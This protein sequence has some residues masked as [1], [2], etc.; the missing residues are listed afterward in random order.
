MVFIEHKRLYMTKGE[1][2]E[3]S[4]TIELDR[5]DTKRAGCDITIVAWSNMVPRTLAAAEVAL[6]A[7][8]QV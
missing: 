2:P 3:E 4:Y 1:V 7:A 8:G 5:G 6:Q